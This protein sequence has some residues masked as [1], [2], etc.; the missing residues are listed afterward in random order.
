MNERAK[1]LNENMIGGAG[2]D[3]LMD[4]HGGAG[5]PLFVFDNVLLTPHAAWYSEESILRRRTQTV[6]SV[7]E[8]LQGR[9]PFSF[10]NR[11]KIQVR[12]AS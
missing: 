12:L 7:L 2:L 11:D 3:V 1:V 5:N 9:E 4:D 10:V 6:E 8:V